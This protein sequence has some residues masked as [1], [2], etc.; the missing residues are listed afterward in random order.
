MSTT[1]TAGPYATQSSTSTI[2]SVVISAGESTASF[3]YGDTKAGTPTLTATDT[4]LKFLTHP[5]GDGQ[6]GDGRRLRG[7]HQLREPRPGRN[8]GHGHRHGDGQVRQCRQGGPN[9]YEGTVDL[10]ATDSQATGP[11]AS[12]TFTAADAGSY[13]FTNVVLKTAGIQTITATDSVTSSIKE[14]TTVNVTASAANQ[15]VFTTPPPSA[16]TAGQAFTV[17]VVAEDPFHN[18][19]TSFNGDVTIALP[20]GTGV[21]DTVQAQHGM[22]TF[23][24]L[25]LDTSASGGAIQAAGGGL[26]AAATSPVIVTT[27]NSPTS[28]PSPTPPTITDEQV[29][30]MRKKNR[31]GKPVGKAVVVGFT[32]DYSAAMNSAT[33]GLAANYQ[34]TSTST[35]RVKKKTVTVHTPVILTSAVY[36]PSTNSVTLNI[37]GNPKF[38]TGGEITVNGSPPSGVSSEGGVHLDASDIEFTILA[39]A[40]GIQLG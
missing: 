25:K 9:Q 16:V 17:I 2:T 37:Q 10:V 19:D 11:P 13:T 22:A 8:G 21:T 31:K 38:A 26:N 20:G 1:G 7:D 15:L 4:A 30:T 40:T 35:K 6:P 29:V 39:K 36:N 3:Y 24:G 14:S 32:L 23:V 34:V 18:V 5:D 28:T 33:A 27:P 12:H